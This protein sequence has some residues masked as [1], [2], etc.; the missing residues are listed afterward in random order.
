MV[1]VMVRNVSAAALNKSSLP[2]TTTTISNG[3]LT[4]TI[5]DNHYNETILEQEV[6]GPNELR[7]EALYTSA[8]KNGVNISKFMEYLSEY[9]WN[10]MRPLS[11]QD[12]KRLL[13]DFS[14]KD[15]IN[16]KDIATKTGVNLDFPTMQ[17]ITKVLPLENKSQKIPTSLQPLT[18]NSIDHIYDYYGN[19]VLN[20]VKYPATFYI[21]STLCWHL[22][23]CVSE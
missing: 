11:Y 2:A 3:M 13:L 5:L 4:I 22:C 16:L 10:T 8:S 17:E 6:K 20:Q 15:G 21:F 7:F 14:R 19:S 12:V 23:V 1:G 18:S 9:S